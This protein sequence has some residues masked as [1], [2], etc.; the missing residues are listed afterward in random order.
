MQGR[1]YRNAAAIAISLIGMLWLTGCPT[2]KKI[3]TSRENSNRSPTNNQDTFN[4]NFAYRDITVSATNRVVQVQGNLVLSS[5][6]LTSPCGTAGDQC[7]CKFYTSTT[8]SA[9]ISDNGTPS[10]SAQNNVYTCTMP[11][12]AVPGNYNYVRVE[13][14]GNSSE[15][16]GLIPISTNLTASQIL[17]S[18]NTSGVRKVYQYTCLRSFLEGQAVTA[19]N[20][21][22][23]PSQQ[24]GFLSAN[25]NFYLYSGGESGDSNFDKKPTEV[26]Y[27]DTYCNRANDPQINC[28]NAPNTL[29]FGLYK[30]ASGPFRVALTLTAA[31]GENAV[32][33]YAGL[34]DSS[35][36]C[37]P[38]FTKI[39]PHTADPPSLSTGT[40]TSIG[41]TMPLPTNFIN[42]NGTLNSVIIDLDGA[43]LAQF[44]VG[45][46][47]NAT[48]CQNDP[49]NGNPCDTATFGGIVTVEQV[50]FVPLTPVLCALP[51]NVI[52]N[53]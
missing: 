30:E 17:G 53:L 23:T 16:S 20:I 24:L 50:D 32:A 10:I 27:F 52:N 41:Y 36:A 51:V 8:D 44:T 42:T 28:V 21:T 4:V 13:V 33:G 34:P 31:P 18:L 49:P 48:P 43:S 11:A 29:K 25:Y 7:A 2:D 35:G 3:F 38:G 39:R 40:T 14:R 46:Q 6:N 37:P 12:T 9:P 15:N 26:T 5:A 1:T 19:T 47:P 22:C 45:R